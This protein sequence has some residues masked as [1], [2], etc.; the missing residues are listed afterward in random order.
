MAET[1]FPYLHLLN[2]SPG[3]SVECRTGSV[4]A[5]HLGPPGR[6]WVCVIPWEAVGNEED[7][8]F[9]LRVSFRLKAMEVLGQV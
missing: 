8:V 9:S 3:S 6:L 1:R 4:E 7:T 5:A 2:R